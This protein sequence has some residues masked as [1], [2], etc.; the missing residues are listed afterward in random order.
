M[1]KAP[2]P[3]KRRPRRGGRLLLLV[4]AVALLHV[5]LI[6]DI[7]L[8]LPQP[9]APPPP[10]EVAFVRELAPS[11]PPPAP[12]A[13]PP[14]PAP[15]PVAHVPQPVAEAASAPKLEPEPEP[16]QAPP[17]PPETEN[18]S[19]QEAATVAEA[20]SAASAPEDA[21]AAPALPPDVTQAAEAASAPVAVAEA[22]ASAPEF[23]AVAEAAPSQPAEAASTPADLPPAQAVPPVAEAA[24]A[25]HQGWPP[26]TQL[27]YELSGWYR[28]EVHGSARVQWLLQDKHYQVHLD[29]VVGPTFAPLMRRRMS[30]DGEIGARGLLPR[31]YDEETR[32]GFLSPRRASVRFEPDAIVLSG[33]TRRVPL[34]GVQDSVSQFVQMTWLFTLRPGLLQ[35]GG[36]LELPLALPRRIDPWIYDVL[37][38]ER[39]ETPVGTLPAVHLK[40]RREPWGDVMTAEA[41]FAPTLQYLPVRLL[42]RQSADVWVD[43]RLKRLPLQAR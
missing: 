33:G 11:V 27:E 38:E 20:A 18:P 13:P 19:P 34:L 36:T 6:D 7:A 42:I 14:P 28:G 37:G 23:P 5:W 29:V 16:E 43:L 21:A 15:P 35:P 26:S 10:M 22:A 25:P 40:P 2:L 24:S 31:R 39:I 3:L 12:A 17:Q 1:P 9:D 30:S 4:L 32:L 8:S 41:W